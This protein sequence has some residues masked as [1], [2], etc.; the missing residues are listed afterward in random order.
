MTFVWL[1]LCIV[2]HETVTACHF[3]PSLSIEAVFLLDSRS[4]ESLLKAQVCWNVTIC[5]LDWSVDKV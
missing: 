1:G 3:L 5:R 2:K 4:F